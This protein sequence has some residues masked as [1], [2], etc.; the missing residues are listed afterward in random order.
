MARYMYMC[1][2]TLFLVCLPFL[3]TCGGSFKAYQHDGAELV[4][5]MENLKTVLEDEDVVAW[6][7]LFQNSSAQ[8]V[9]ASWT[10]LLQIKQKFGV[11]RFSQLLTPPQL[12][13]ATFTAELGSI[14]LSA[15]YDYPISYEGQHLVF[16]TV[17]AFELEKDSTEWQLTYFTIHHP[18]YE[19]EDL[20]ADLTV[21]QPT[22]FWS[23][24]MDWEASPDPSPLLARTYQALVDE[25]IERLKQC[26][27]HGV[28]YT[29]NQRGIRLATIAI[30]GDDGAYNRWQTDNYYTQ[31]ILELKR[32]AKNLNTTPAELTPLFTTYEILDMPLHCTQLK[33]EFGYSGR[34]LNF[35]THKIT[36]SWTGIWL[37]ERWL[38]ESMW[39]ESGTIATL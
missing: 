39:V 35:G 15:W 19:Y 21:L 3:S 9:G 1:R 8:S 23:M 4:E 16:E 38:S 29:A 22:T 7:A 11:T 26:C 32:M 33:L 2:V 6:E 28:Y 20:A 10:D 34:G 36:V 31:Q 30:D 5:L 27:I 24:D 17:W 25:D 13:T 14:T 37:H 12:G 18:A